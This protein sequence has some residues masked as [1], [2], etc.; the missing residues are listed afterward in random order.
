MGL[1]RVICSG[2]AGMLCLIPMA[3][4]SFQFL[5]L[6]SAVTGGLIE[7]FNE[8]FN[9]L[10]TFIPQGGELIGII[11][12]VFF[13]LA[14]IF[15]FPIHWCIMYRPDDV[16][17]LIAVV[18]PWILCCSITA[19]LFAHSPVGGITTSIAI[20]IGY[21][22]PAIAIYFAIPAVLGSVAGTNA[23]G[24]L[25][26]GIIDGLVTGLTDLPYVFA[27]TAAILEGAGVGAVFGAFIGSLKYKPGEG[28]SSL[29]SFGSE[30]MEEPSFG[31]DLGTTSKKSA[32]PADFCTNCGAKLSADDEFC[33]NCGAKV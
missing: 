20:G 15:L 5:G 18:V 8:L 17:L 27:V 23:G 10:G 2:C 16:M 9:S 31:S 30:D 24:A 14:L 28:E 1:K 3:Y 32:E 26:S 19:G 7:N 22:V 21:L 6:T 11:G 33:T 29:K 4:V 25:A 12:S 13:G